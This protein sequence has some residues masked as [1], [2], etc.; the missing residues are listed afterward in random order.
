MPKQNPQ[1]RVVRKSAEGVTIKTMDGSFSD[2]FSW[3]DFNANF[4][5]TADKYIYEMV[6]R[7]EIREEVD[8]MALRFKFLT[9]YLPRLLMIMNYPNRGIKPSLEYLGFVG[10]VVRAYNEQFEGIS[11]LQ[12]VEDVQ[13]MKNAL[14]R[15]LNPL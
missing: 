14:Q 13:A 10:A 5:P 3:E 8:A 4:V 7:E 6:L 9:P 15:G 1:V 12:L 11:P 2:T